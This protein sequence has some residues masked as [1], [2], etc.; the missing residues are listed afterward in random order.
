MNSLI[1]RLGGSLYAWD[2]GETG[3]SRMC[4]K[5]SRL[6]VLTAEKSANDR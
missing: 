6:A 2:G 3:C 1:S 4:K 5:N